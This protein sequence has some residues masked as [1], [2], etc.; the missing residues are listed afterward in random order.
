MWWAST[1]SPTLTTPTSSSSTTPSNCW[2]PAWRWAA[3]SPSS[4]PRRHAR[5]APQ[6][7]TA[8]RRGAGGKADEHVNLIPDVVRLLELTGL[9][10]V[11]ENVPGARADL[12]NAFTLTGGMFGLGVHRP[13]LFGSNYLV[14]LPRRPAA[15]PKDALGV[16]GK[17]HDGRLLFKRADGT[18]QHAASSLAQGPGR[19]GHR[20]DGLGPTSEE[21]RA[22]RLHRMDRAATDR[23][24]GGSRMNWTETESIRQG[25]SRG[26]TAL[27]RV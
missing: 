27:R 15:P 2:A 26:G 7:R 10:W 3:T 18:E 17:A 11:V 24:T 8:G 12:P 1:S 25:R 9:P 4:T 13:R 6:C 16:Y 21:S 20:L 19:H 22:A 23:P 14:M 5:Q